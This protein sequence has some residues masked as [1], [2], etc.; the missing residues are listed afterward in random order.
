[1]TI[2]KRLARQALG[3]QAGEPTFGGLARWKHVVIH[4]Y[5]LEDGHSYRE[6]E[7]RLR[8]FSELRDVLELDLDD[9]PDYSTIYKSFDRFSMGR[10]RALLRVSAQQHPQSGHVALDSTF[11]ER[12]QVSSYYLD[13]SDRTVQ[14]L[15]VT[16]LTDT[17]SLAVLDVQCS[18]QWK[19]D[20][21]LG[22][23]VVRRN[24][25]DLLSVAVD[26]AFQDWKSKFEFYTLNVDPL[27][28]H[29][30]SAPLTVGHNALIRE[31]GY[32]QRWIAETSYSTVK[33][34]LGSAVRAQFWYREFREI[35]LK[36]AIS[37]I[38]QLCEPL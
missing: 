8:C 20:T 30:G 33:R 23:Q 24:A 36:F 15:K 32:S 13:R 9:V 25:D 11:F 28:L 2:C 6:T 38:E 14:T 26:K 22:P 21:K 18:A 19:H 5:R 29:Q 31:K 12:R 34:S 27:I 10:W 1:M 16:T 35:V 4:C 7:N 17:Q 37:N 3:N